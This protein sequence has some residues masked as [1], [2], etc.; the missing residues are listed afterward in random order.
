MPHVTSLSSS[1]RCSNLQVKILSP[2]FIKIWSNSF[3]GKGKDLLSMLNYGTFF[4]SLNGHTLLIPI[5]IPSYASFIPTCSSSPATAP[6][7]AVHINIPGPSNLL[8]ARN[9]NFQIFG[10]ISLTYF[11]LCPYLIFSTL[12]LSLLFKLQPTYFYLALLIF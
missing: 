12:T 5:F 6:T 1:A 9:A 4:I 7:H 11:W 2:S 10:I 8:S 3:W